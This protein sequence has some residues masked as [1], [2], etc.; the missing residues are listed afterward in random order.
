V[1]IREQDAG[2]Q[3]I[4]SGI[5]LYDTA[6]QLNQHLANLSKAWWQSICQVCSEA[7]SWTC[8][9]EN[10]PMSKFH[11]YPEIATMNP[12]TIPNYHP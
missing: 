3:P 4:S 1:K 9:E 7:G 8:R 12:T 10:E 5:P 11:D 2:Y 6:G